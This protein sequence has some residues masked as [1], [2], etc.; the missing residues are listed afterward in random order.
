MAIERSK[1]IT[2]AEYDEIFSTTSGTTDA[3]I[4]EA[5]E[6]IDNYTKG[7]SKQF[8]VDTARDLLKLA[9]AYQINYMKGG[10]Y[11]LTYSDINADDGFSLGDLSIAGNAANAEIS[12]DRKQVSPRVHGYLLRDNLLYKGL[13]GYPGSGS[14][15]GGT[16]GN[17]NTIDLD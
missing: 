10:D 2:V 15:C 13:Q 9:T 16:N 5:S 7:R 17:A 4:I 14:S 6:V 8:D 12:N 11:S 1:Y 3:E